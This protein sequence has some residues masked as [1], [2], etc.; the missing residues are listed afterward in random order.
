MDRVGKGITAAEGIDRGTRRREATGGTSARPAEGAVP[1]RNA[2]FH[3]RGHGAA[4]DARGCA[5]DALPKPTARK[6]TASAEVA[7]DLLVGV[8]LHL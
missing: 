6:R 4:R 8:R 5:E 3:E 1:L 7:R 2:P